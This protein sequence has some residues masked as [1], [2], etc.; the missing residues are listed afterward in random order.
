MK[1]RVDERIR[2]VMSSFSQE[3]ESR[4]DRVVELFTEKGFLLT[5][6]H[7]KKL[8]KSTWELRAGNVRLLFGIVGDEA[9]IV[10]VFVKKTQQTPKKEID[11]A[12]R[13]LK[14]YL[15]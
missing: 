12:L 9:I 11:L 8:I 1:V 2:K 3:E 7:L 14:E 15:I 4:I 6:V 10:N 5:E 13:R